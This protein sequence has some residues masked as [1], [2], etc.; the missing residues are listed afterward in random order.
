LSDVAETSSPIK[1]FKKVDFPAFGAPT[2]Q[3]F[4]KNY[5]FGG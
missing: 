3:A 5:S 2:M 4:R 1:A